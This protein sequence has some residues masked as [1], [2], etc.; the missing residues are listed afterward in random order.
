[1]TKEQAMEK[2]NPDKHICITKFKTGKDRVWTIE[3]K[4][5]FD[6]N[7]LHYD[8]LDRQSIRSITG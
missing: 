5:K 4:P 7:I 1:M 8:F 3:H 6:S 2:Y